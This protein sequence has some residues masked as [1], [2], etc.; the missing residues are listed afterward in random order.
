MPNTHGNDLVV[1][2]DEEAYLKASFRRFA[3][4]Y[5]LGGLA[6]F[7]IASL[8]LIGRG[9]EPHVD[10]KPLITQPMLDEIKAESLALRTQ[11]SRVLERVNAVGEDLSGAA[12]RV[13]ELERRV[14]RVTG[15]GGVG[16]TEL[17]ALR[18]R[19]DDA[20]RRIALLEETGAKLEARAAL[21]AP[22]PARPQEP[23]AAPAPFPP[24]PAG[25]PAAAPAPR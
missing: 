9:A 1:S 8:W 6:I 23:P 15:R 17:A 2:S 16:G 12:R 18:K 20:D 24:G 25:P 7:A 21:T 19:L 10:V 11:L 14:E 13:D 5:M 22:P 4:P 3:L